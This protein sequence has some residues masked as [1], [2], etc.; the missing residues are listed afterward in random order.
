M[1]IVMTK[2]LSTAQCLPLPTPLVEPE[3][4]CVTHL[5]PGGNL[6]T[7]PSLGDRV[8]SPPSIFSAP[9]PSGSGARALGLAGA[10]TAVADDATAASWNPAGLIQL[11]RPE[12]SFVLRTSHETNKH[13]SQNTDL[14]VG[15]DDFDS[16]NLNYFSLV[17]PFYLRHIKRNLV[18]SLNYQEA[19]DFTQHFSANLR[20]RST[21]TDGLEVTQEFNKPEQV[22]INTPLGGQQR[23]LTINVLTTTQVTSSFDQLLKFN[24]LS[25]L[26]FE[27]DGIIEALSPALAIELTPKLAMGIALNYYQDSALF[28]HSIESRTLATIDGTS[29]SRVD[30]TTTR[31]S[32]GSFDIQGTITLPNDS[33]LIPVDEQGT[34]GPFSETMETDTSDKL[35]VNGTFE[36]TNRFH[37][38]HGYNATLGWLWSVSRHL[39]LGAVVDLPWTADTEQVRRVK[40]NITATDP[41]T[42]KVRNIEEALE[43]EKA[44]VTFRFPLYWAVGMVWRWSDLFY[45]TLDISQTLWSDFSFKAEDGERINPLNGRPHREDPLDDTW[46]IRLG[47]EYLLVFPR[48]EIP[49]RSGVAW[50]QRPTALDPQDY[51]SFSLG[52]GFSVGKEPGKTVVD[53]AYVLTSS[54]GA[55]GNVVEQTDL[56][57]DLIEHQA[58][59]SCIFHF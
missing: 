9:L 42:E 22:Q 16:S 56:T 31:R 34:F 25:D 1:V 23:D 36:E 3:E 6:V 5:G 17:Y 28:G 37:D 38:L 33:R 10:F 2:H 51:Y 14:R 44:D 52:S 30:M 50:E 12:A 29:D 7:P 19:Y 46:S 48:T 43:I 45:T 21:P 4:F 54:E 40:R 11:E 55:P 49:L 53:I 39:S 13:Q 47:L 27:Q 8:F 18:V 59:L 32:S 57:L 24:L 15:D 58:F 41:R 26:T 20:D 35:R